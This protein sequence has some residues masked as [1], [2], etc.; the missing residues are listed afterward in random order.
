M[1]ECPIESYRNN[2]STE[3]ISL[4]TESPLNDLKL[5]HLLGSNLVYLTDLFQLAQQSR[6][7]GWRA[8]HPRYSACSGSASHT[9]AHTKL[10]LWGP[11]FLLRWVVSLTIRIVYS[12]CSPQGENEGCCFNI[13][14]TSHSP[15]LL[16]PIQTWQNL[17]LL[18]LLP[19]P[20]LP[21][22]LKAPLHW[23]DHLQMAPDNQGEKSER[24]WL[25]E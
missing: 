13:T 12:D 19:R 21:Q 23:P 18:P 3:K 24:P 5:T 1:R 6:T 11:A 2:T 25:S 9:H 20:Q 22:L 17:L 16:W 14:W 15:R 7:F 4:G 8:L 10:I